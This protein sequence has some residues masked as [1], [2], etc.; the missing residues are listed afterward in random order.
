MIVE[1]PREY[2]LA[3]S[4]AR[5]Y[6]S[7]ATSVFGEVDLL[8]ERTNQYLLVTRGLAL[9]FLPPPVMR[10]QAA[11]SLTGLESVGDKVECTW[12]YGDGP[13]AA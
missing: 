8:L 6:A 4:E 2:A 12:C 5:E 10:S 1:G 11:P 7:S 9:A 3:Y 13:T